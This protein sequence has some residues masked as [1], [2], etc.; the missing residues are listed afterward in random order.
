M[1]PTPLP[2]LWDIEELAAYLGVGRRYVYR[3]TEQR[4]IR[5]VRIAGRLRFR[6]EDELEWL[7][8]ESREPTETRRSQGGRPRGR[9]RTQR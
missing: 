4:R 5:F 8:R 6:P 9:A 2:E 3:L 7:A 1:E